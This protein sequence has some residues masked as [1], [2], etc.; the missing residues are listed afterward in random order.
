MPMMLTY[1]KKSVRTVKKNAE[2]IV[3]AT[4]QIGAEVNAD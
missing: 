1:W 2:A 3:V 4:T